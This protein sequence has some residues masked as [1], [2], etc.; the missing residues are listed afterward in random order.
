MRR[1]FDEFALQCQSMNSIASGLNRDGI[2]APRGGKWHVATVKE[3]LRQRAYR[4]DFTYN[5]RKSGQFY[6][7]DE[8]G[9]VV[10][11]NQSTRAKAWQTTDLWR[12]HQ[13]WGLQGIN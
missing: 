4:G 11:A 2:R 1:I 7:C 10:E 13:G 6:I 9:A 3:L 12:N 5:R 8:K